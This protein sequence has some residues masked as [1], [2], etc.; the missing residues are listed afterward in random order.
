[1]FCPLY[2]RV[3]LVEGARV[4]FVGV[5]PM[6]WHEHPEEPQAG[7]RPVQ[8]HELEMFAALIREYPNEP[9]ENL[10]AQVWQ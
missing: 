1:M 10:A 4:N 6:R 5:H 9:V 7:F 2:V 8:D 3:N